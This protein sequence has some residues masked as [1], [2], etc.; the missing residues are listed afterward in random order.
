[1]EKEKDQHDSGVPASPE[2]HEALLRKHDAL[3]KHMG[4]GSH[5]SHHCGPYPPEEDE[6]L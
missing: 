3:M 2:D 5:K 6:T 1:M 4:W